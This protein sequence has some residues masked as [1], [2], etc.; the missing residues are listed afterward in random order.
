MTH[1]ADTHRRLAAILVADMVGSTRL[2]E[3]DEEYTHAWLMRLRAE[4]LEPGIAEHGGQTVKNTGDGFIAIFDTARD[5]TRC[6]LALQQAVAVE[7]AEQPMER[8]I[9]YRLAVNVAD[10]I[11][12]S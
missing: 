2:M 3:A 5:A 12:E 4:V 7:T 6:A 9:S 1:L 11:V 10:I 8:R